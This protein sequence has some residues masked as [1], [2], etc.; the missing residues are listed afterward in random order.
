[1]SIFDSIRVKKPSKS[2]F[3]L[4]HD[5]KLSMKMGKLVP[6]MFTEC[7]PG[8]RFT[9]NSE[10]LVRMQPMISPI[11]HK[12]DIT[13]H[14]FFV[15]YRIL[16]ANWEKFITGGAESQ[17]EPAPAVPVMAPLSPEASSLAD[18]LGVPLRTDITP[19]VVGIS[20]VSALP[21][22]AY[23]RIWF[24]YYRD[25]NLI[26]PGEQP[27]SLSDGEQSTAVSGDLSILRTRAWEHDYFTSCLPFAQKGAPVMLPLADAEVVLKDDLSGKQ[28]KVVD[29]I[30]T[31][32]TGPLAADF[33]SDL[34][35]GASTT[36]FID[37]NGTMVVGASATTIN[38]LRTAWTLQK[39][40][41]KNARAGSRYVESILAHFGVK[42]QDSRLQRPEYIG[43]SKSTM[44]ISEVLQTSSTDSTTPQANMAG[45]G[46]S[47]QGGATQTYFAQEHGCIITIMSVIPKTCYQQGL[48]KHF[49]RKSRL[50]YYWPDFAYLGEQEVLNKEIFVDPDDNL[51]DE[52]FGYLPRYS[53]YRY[54]PSRVAGTMR[55]TLSFW[56]LG[57]IFENRP[58]LNQSFIEAKPSKR[59]FAV[60]DPAV[61]ELICH[62]YHKISALRPIPRYGT[63][64][65]I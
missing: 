54:I 57:R 6:V 40:L 53:E 47:V 27:I 50:D 46:V 14:S 56:H 49:S 30:H 18:Y 45:H 28:Q 34:V 65:G 21:F 15:P 60:T 64:G 5:V 51:D 33:T 22:A 7:I 13:L 25:Q 3:D 11:M 42:S 36:S 24:E 52:V 32:V 17:V 62:V 63:P 48:F 44:S 23:Q 58:L 41:E 12:V 2:V 35:T 37:P 9:I 20:D 16:W 31:G 26:K 4:S 1:M 38:D 55:T 19:P 43:G 39:W 8:D 10:A 59:V 29:D 61:D